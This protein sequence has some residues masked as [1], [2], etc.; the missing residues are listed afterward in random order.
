MDA[1]TIRDNAEREAWAL[2]SGAAIDRA[3]TSSPTLA[4]A[5]TRARGRYRVRGQVVQVQG[6]EL[7]GDH[8]SNGTAAGLAQGQPR[9]LRIPQAG[10]AAFGAGDAQYRSRARALSAWAPLALLDQATM[11][12]RSR[13]DAIRRSRDGSAFFETAAETFRRRSTE[14][15]S[16][17]PRT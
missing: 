9:E 8:G 13:E 16:R 4:A 12:I 17:R 5:P 11:R 1:A 15:G 3:S 2:R 6:A 7:N 10:P 14:G